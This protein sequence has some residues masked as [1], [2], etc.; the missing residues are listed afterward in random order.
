LTP[1]DSSVSTPPPNLTFRT[2]EPHERGAVLDLLHEWIS[3]E[4]FGRYFE[5]DPAFRDD[6]CFVAAAGERLVSTLQ[7][8]TKHVRVDGAVVKVGGVGN[9]YTTPAYRDR[10]LASQLLTRAVAAME[11]R[12]FDLSLLFAVRLPFYGRLG[13]ASHLRRFVFIDPGQPQPSGRYVLERFDAARDLDR[14]ME[15]YDAYSGRHPGTVVRDRQY[16]EGQLH[17]AGNPAEDFFVAR[18]ANDAAIVAYA[19]ATTL[20]DF[21]VVIEHGYAPGHELALSDLVCRLHAIE[22]AALPGTLTQ[23]VCEPQVIATLRARGLTPRTVDDVFWMWRVLAPDRL[24]RKLGIS[25]T[26]VARDDFLTRLFPPDR[27]V[28]WLSDRC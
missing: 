2:I 15:I 3:R 24:A 23:L 6:L 18:S 4:F 21:Y 25:T 12:G 13:W 11:E 22:G 19:R 5:Y 26:E 9:V 10:R 28:Y 8:F 7:V 16:W 14:L 27:A 20:Y 1:F 17:Y